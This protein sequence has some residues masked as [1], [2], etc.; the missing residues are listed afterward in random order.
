MP[1]KTDLNFPLQGKPAK[2]LIS[3]VISSVVLREGKNSDE[4]LYNIKIA[5][6]PPRFHFQCS[7][8]F[9]TF[10]DNMISK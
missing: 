4:M 5:I 1:K 9:S 8:N 2:W 7:E 3:W 10:P 6:K